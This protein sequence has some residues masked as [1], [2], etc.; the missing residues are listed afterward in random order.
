[1]DVSPEQQAVGDMIGVRPAIWLQVCGLKNGE[2]GALSYGTL[3][4]IGLNKPFPETRLS[5]A[6]ND[7][8]LYASAGIRITGWWIVRILCIEL[9]PC[10]LLVGILREP[11]R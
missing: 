1:M 5:L 6:G 11:E 4:T 2:H 9:S 3:A 7:L 10:G 8:S